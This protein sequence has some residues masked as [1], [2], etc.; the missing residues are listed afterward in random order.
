MGN[1]KR[2]GGAGT[3]SGA[4]LAGF[5]PSATGGRAGMSG[6]SGAQRKA[7]HR[8][9]GGVGRDQDGL[10][11]LFAIRGGKRDAETGGFEQAVVGALGVMLQALAEGEGEEREENAVDHDVPAGGFA[12]INGGQEA[13]QRTVAERAQ[14]AELDAPDMAAGF[15]ERPLAVAGRQAVVELDQFPDLPARGVMI[16]VANGGKFDREEE[17]VAETFEKE[18]YSG[19]IG[20]T[21]GADQ[22]GQCGEGGQAG[23]G[24]ERIGQGGE[25]R[26]QRGAGGG[27]LGGAG[28]VHG[29][30]VEVSTERAGTVGR[31]YAGANRILGALR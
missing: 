1:R 10:L 29:L 14:P 2:P 3:G 26:R 17:E 31:D 30:S 13:L 7:E 27:G 9:D 4:I 5:V 28:G 18:P 19:R 8:L 6:G 15:G 24:S 22:F 25:V 21:G 20:G 23:R 11:E 16:G 12:L